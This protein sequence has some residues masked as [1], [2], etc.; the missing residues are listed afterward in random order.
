MVLP[1][2]YT[3]EKPVAEILA[4]HASMVSAE[5]VSLSDFVAAVQAGAISKRYIVEV[6]EQEASALDAA[7][8][9]YSRAIA[10]ISGHFIAV[11]TEEPVSS[12]PQTEAIYSRRLSN[13][14]SQ[15][16]VGF[17]PYVDGT[18]LLITPELTAGILTGLFFLFVIIIG[19]SCMNDIGTPDQFAM[20][21]PLP[22]KEF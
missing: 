15:N 5:L 11:I 3:A 1:Y 12:V 14:L 6:A 4:A 13:D 9:S 21:N 10:A 17:T 7:V 18:Y 8:L 19:F 16:G 22:G 20:E 2:V